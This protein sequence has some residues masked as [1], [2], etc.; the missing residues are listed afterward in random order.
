[1][2]DNLDI[3]VPDEEITWFN[4]NHTEITADENETVHYHGGSLFFLNL[5]PEDSGLYSA[6]W[7]HYNGL[8]IDLF[9]KRVPCFWINLFLPLRHNTSSGECN[10]KVEI[11]VVKKFVYEPIV[12]SD[13]NK[14][15]TCPNHVRR[16]CATLRGELTWNKVPA[17]RENCVW[18]E[19][20]FTGYKRE[21]CTVDPNVKINHL[22]GF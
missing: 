20:M 17:L 3:N 8:L 5:L 12:N 1:M 2:H 15:V 16:T 21:I 14:K 22:F 4:N 19:S 11:D 9:C 13:I 6:R 7:G 10:Y 18:I